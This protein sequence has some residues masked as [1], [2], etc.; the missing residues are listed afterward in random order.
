M[1]HAKSAEAA[2]DTEALIK[3]SI[4]AVEKGAKVAIKAKDSLDLAVEKTKVVEAMIKE[5][6]AASEQQALSATQILAGVEQISS[7]VQTNSATA[8]ESA[9]A[10][11]ELSSQAQILKEMVE[12]IKLSDS[13]NYDKA[14]Y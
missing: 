12:E 7:I 4:I 11:E 6:S 13:I 2:K 5:I 9:A 8:E 3:N 10:S 1:G 14:I